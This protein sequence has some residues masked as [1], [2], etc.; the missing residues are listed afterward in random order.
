MASKHTIVEALRMMLIAPL[1]P[2]VQAQ[3][4]AIIKEEDRIKAEAE[5]LKQAAWEAT[6]K[7]RAA[8]KVCSIC[9]KPFDNSQ[10]KD[11]GGDC[12]TCMAEVGE[13]SDCIK[14]LAKLKKGV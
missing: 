14:A 13:D 2:T 12:L 10:H 5:R 11:C 8:Q 9:K 6:G 3:A 7:K 1:S 4:R